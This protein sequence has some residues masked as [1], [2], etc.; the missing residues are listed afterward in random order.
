MPEGLFEC[1]IYPGAFNGLGLQ[2]LIDAIRNVAWED[3]SGVQLFIQAQEEDRLKEVD[4]GLWPGTAC[5]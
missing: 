1:N 3:P 2:E 4:L 5:D